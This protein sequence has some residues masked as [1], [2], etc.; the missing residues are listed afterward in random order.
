MNTSE[1]EGHFSTRTI[2]RWRIG[3][4]ALAGILLAVPWV[5]M[6]FTVEV[7]WTA[8]DFILFGALL[9]LAGLLV[10]GIVRINRER[11]FIIGA[12]LAVGTAFLLVWIELA[13]GIIGN[14]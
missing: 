9:G 2:S 14:S 6:R 3:L 1:S 11:R 13:V 10:E 4:W 8:S 5:A 7:V 12:V